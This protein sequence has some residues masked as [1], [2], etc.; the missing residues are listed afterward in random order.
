MT[1]KPPIDELDEFLRQ[2]TDQFVAL[3]ERIARSAVDGRYSEGV[4]ISSLS[5]LLAEAQ[6]MADLYGRR[7]AFLELDAMSSEAARLRA[8]VP[9]CFAAEK[10]L[11]VV[12]F[13]AAID[14]LLSREPR[15]A[16]DWRDVADVYRGERGFALAKSSST[17]ITARVQAA[18]GTLM[19]TGAS[20][21]TAENVIAAIGGW[22]KSYADTVYRTNVATA[23]SAG[24]IRAGFQPDVLEAMPAWELVTAQDADVRRG[25]KQDRGEN[26]LAGHGLIAAKVDKIWDTA[27]PPNGYNCLLPDTVVDGPFTGGMRSCYE[28]PAFEIQTRN[29]SRFTVTGNHPVATFSGMKPA[30][31]LTVGEYCVSDRLQLKRFSMLN[32]HLPDVLGPNPWTEND[33]KVPARA[34]DVFEALRGHGAG[35]ARTNSARVT[36]ADLH[37][38][39]VFVKGEIDVVRAYRALPTDLKAAANKGVDDLD[40]VLAA[41]PVPSLDGLGGLDSLAQGPRPSGGRGP[42]SATLSPHDLAVIS[43]LL[44]ELPLDDLGFRWVSNGDVV[45][46]ENAVDRPAAYALFLRE[47]LEAR[48]S[49][50]FADEIVSVRQFDFCGHVY[51]FQTENGWM[52][53]HGSVISNCRD[54]VRSVDRE[55]L[56]R[57]GL[58][59]PDGSVRILHPADWKNFA[60]HPDFASGR[61]D[62]TFYR[63]A[64]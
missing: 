47:L 53:A 43:P 30:K 58:L 48:P 51:D 2:S 50:V 63:G 21:A 22:S 55:E 61:P 23:Y 18:I 20:A 1:V 7:R 29:G 15:L 9:V 8:T 42:G 49:Q 39:A 36:T 32:G 60:P 56:Q 33:Q 13:Q 19:K 11:P 44:S 4:A 34:E 52:L 57:K 26:H 5:D 27:Y 12:P 31:R 14:D 6:I 3:V 45:L 35:V 28:G 64:A 40:L 24:R 62:L 17:V 38:D 16:A 59:R 10:I 37:G 41:H 54:Q 25:R 46:P